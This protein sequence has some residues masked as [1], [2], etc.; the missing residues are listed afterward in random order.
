MRR[1]VKSLLHTPTVRAK[2]LA[3]QGRTDEYVHALEVLYGIQVEDDSAIGSIALGRARSMQATSTGLFRTRHMS[4]STL[5]S[6]S[7]AGFYPVS[8]NPALP[9]RRS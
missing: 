1:T 4:P 7:A 2:M 3:A 8:Y 9:A 5:P 6:V